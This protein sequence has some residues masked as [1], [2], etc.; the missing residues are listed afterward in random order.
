MIPFLLFQLS[1]GAASAVEPADGEIVHVTAEDR[2][3]LV[4]AVTRTV[5]VT[6]YDRTILI[7]EKPT[8]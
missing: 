5:S 3:I 7:E 1:A 2:T 4:E 6:A 8:P